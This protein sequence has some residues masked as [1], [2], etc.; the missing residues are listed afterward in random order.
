MDDQKKTKL[1]IAGVVAATI[2]YCAGYA[3]GQQNVIKTLSE[4]KL[5]IIHI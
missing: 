5:A 1:W 2:V 3:A 4:T